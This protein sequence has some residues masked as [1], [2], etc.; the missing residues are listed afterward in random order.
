MVKL[1][2]WLRYLVVF[3]CATVLLSCAEGPRLQEHRL[4]GST[5]G[6]T[7]NITYVAESEIENLKI[8]IDSLLVDFNQVAS[9]YI[10]DSEISSFNRSLST[11]RQYVDGSIVEML[12]LAKD[13]HQLSGGAF[14]VTMAPLIDLWGF[15]AANVPERVP[16]QQARDEAMMVMGIDKLNWYDDEIQKVNP[17][18]QI[19][20]SAIAKGYGT[21]VLAEALEVRGIQNY[22]VEIG[23]EMRLKGLKANGEKWRVAIEKPDSSSRSVQQIIKVSNV[24]IAT[25]GDYRNYIEVDGKRYSHLIDPRSGFPITHNLASVTVL[26]DTC[27]EADGWATA[28]SVLGPVESKRLAAELDIAVLLLTKDDSSFVEYRSDAW[29]ALLENQRNDDGDPKVSY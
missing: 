25:S 4:Q 24:A 16:D 6:T 28:F 11:E 13:I 20:L 19:N 21:D 22:L 26:A 7:Y 15:D 2:M 18:V 12:T 23:G 27:A 3:S 14:D 10:S 17:N 8:D 1:M 9:T 5:M 29:L